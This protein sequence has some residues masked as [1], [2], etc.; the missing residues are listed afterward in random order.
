MLHEVLP[1][2]ASAPQ[3]SCIYNG[4]RLVFFEIKWKFL[5][6][7]II[8]AFFSLHVG[9]LGALILGSH[10]FRLTFFVEAPGTCEKLFQCDS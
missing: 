2:L 1:V 10:F 8:S 6:V 7:R 3:G 9:S 5:A 4:G